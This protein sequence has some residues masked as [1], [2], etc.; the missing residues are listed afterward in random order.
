MHTE[1]SNRKKKK[2]IKKKKK[3]IVKQILNTNFKR[4]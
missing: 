2:H 4:K 1:I 3:K